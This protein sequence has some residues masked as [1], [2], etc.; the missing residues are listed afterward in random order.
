MYLIMSQLTRFDRAFHDLDRSGALIYG[1]AGFTLG[2]YFSYLALALT[3]FYVTRAMIKFS[4]THASGLGMKHTLVNRALWRM[5]IASA[6]PLLVS[7]WWAIVI[8]MRVAEQTSGIGGQY[9]IRNNPYSRVNDYDSAHIIYTSY[10]LTSASIFVGI[11][12][13]SWCCKYYLDMRRS[14]QTME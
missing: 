6:V 12:V 2:L 9:D 10:L 14:L 13:I 11:L 8:N 1:E 4:R 5:R 3:C 7:L